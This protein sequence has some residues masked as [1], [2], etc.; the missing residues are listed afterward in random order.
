[1]EETEAMGGLRISIMILL[2]EQMVPAEL[3]VMQLQQVR[4]R[5]TRWAAMEALFTVQ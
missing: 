5:Y 4:A 2:G 3:V 1:M